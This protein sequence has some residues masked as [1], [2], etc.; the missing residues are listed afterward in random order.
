LLSTI[1]WNPGE[2][3][4]PAR[5]RKIVAESAPDLV[6]QER[7]WYV[8]VQSNI[9]HDA[10]SRASA[11]V[12]PFPV[13]FALYTLTGDLDGRAAETEQLRPSSDANEAR[14]LSVNRLGLG[15]AGE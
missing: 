9:D 13:G 12:A 8:I 6:A 15:P 7:T 2:R 4:S 5:C 3:R 1:P 14:K 11:G 10:R